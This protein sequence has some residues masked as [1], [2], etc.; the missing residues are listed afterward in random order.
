MNV[1]KFESSLATVVGV[2]S[3]QNLISKAQLYQNFLKLPRQNI[4]LEVSDYC[5]CIP[6]EAHDFFHNIWSKQFCDS[7]KP[8]KEEIQ[9][10]ISLARNVIEPKLLAKHVV[11]QFQQAHPELNFHKLSLNQFV[12]HQ[13]NRKEKGSVK[14]NQTPDVSVNDI[15]TLLRKLMQ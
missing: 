14:E 13:I 4:W 5:G 9:T 11:A 6:Q 7:Y 10:Y 15:K 2:K 1:T 3:S 12:H 8:F